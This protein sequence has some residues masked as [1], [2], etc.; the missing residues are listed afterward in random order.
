MPFLPP[1]QQHQRT[2][3]LFFNCHLLYDDDNVTVC[4]NKFLRAHQ[5]YVRL[6]VGVLLALGGLLLR[7][8]VSLP[9]SPSLVANKPIIHSSSTG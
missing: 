6:R 2:E 4:S 5:H 1:N 9:V 3:A 7:H 8:V